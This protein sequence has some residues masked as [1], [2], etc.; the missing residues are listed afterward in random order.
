MDVSPEPHSIFLLAFVSN[1][2]GLSYIPEIA[3]GKTNPKDHKKRYRGPVHKRYNEHQWKNDAE[4]R[5][6]GVRS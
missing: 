3:G 1:K 4:N 5:L 2:E 6:L